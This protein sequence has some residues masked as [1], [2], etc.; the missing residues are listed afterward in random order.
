MNEPDNQLSTLLKQW[1]APEPR[2]ALE[3]DI[4]RRVRLAATAAPA[5]ATGPLA[6]L[7]P[8]W[9]QAPW[10]LATAAGAALALALL[11]GLATELV[12][13]P[14]GAAATATR[15]PGFSLLAPGTVAGNYVALTSGGAQP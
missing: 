6:G 1:P 12:L 8:A 14:P 3:Q 2:A 10:R 15:L 9:L 4:L 5:P 7:L 11:T 13:P